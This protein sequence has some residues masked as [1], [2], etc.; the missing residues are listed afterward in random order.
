MQE[1]A[2]RRSAIKLARDT[3]LRSGR[4]ETR[5][6]PDIVAAS[7]L[8]S[9]SAGVDASTAQ[10]IYHNDLDVT[11][12]LV[13]CSEAAIARLGDEM[14][15][16]PLSIVLTDHK[17]RILWRSERDRGIGRLLD[18]VSLAPGFNYAEDSVGTNGIG[19]V[20]ESG[21]PLYIVGPEHFHEQLQPF[22]CAGSPIR[23]PLTNRVEGVLDITCL[24][25]FA[26]PLMH[27]LVRSAAHEIEQNLLVDRSQC[28]Q[29]LFEAFVRVDARTH[30]AVMAI[31]GTMVM[32]NA[33]AQGLF[34]PG[35][36]WAIHEHARYLM[37]SRGGPADRIELPS[38]R[39]VHL[40]G[41]RVVVGAD[42]AG[43]VVVVSLVEAGSAVPMS[44]AP[45]LAPALPAGAGTA[46]G[47][48]T[49][50]EMRAAAPVVAEQPTRFGDGRSLLW[51]RACAGISEALVAAEPL[52]VIGESGCGKR[53]LV[54]DLFERVV[55]GGRTREF[56]AEDLGDLHAEEAAGAA[57]TERTL[58]IVSNINR[59]DAEG[60]AVFDS[61]LAA[62]AGSGRPVSVAAT[63]SDADLD[64]D[65][66]FRAVLAHFE[67]AVTV[68]PL[69]HRTEDIA[70]LVTHLLRGSPGQRGPGVSTAAMRVLSRY[71]WPRNIRQLE[72]AL[73]F[74]RL[75]RPVG[76]IQPEDLPGYCHSGAQRQLSTLEA[77]ERD[78][79]VTALHDAEGNRA[80]TAAMLGIAR[81]SL[82][83]K[84][85][86]FGIT[87][88]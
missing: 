54:A 53:S 12:R 88:A 31:G 18:G 48:E 67:K 20:L 45:V 73:A 36:Q 66:P 1:S 52:L 30:A 40:R 42:V 24:S 81:S 85:K 82:Y 21:R 19:T 37:T 60:V 22:A 14:A 13:R 29:A 41:T 75:K 25:E 77:G 9:F 39:H 69:R 35:E 80:R 79:I 38:G 56:A 58:Y 74:A 68:A 10:A 15:E 55:A 4:T 83:R 47:P 71:D 32:G 59:L 84:L 28:Q 23:D 33:A 61:F 76:E 86:T 44:Q 87:A 70:L 63:V 65:L 51:K 50:A 7:W 11:G 62:L 26:S 5:A 46:M 2:D 72:E 27:S 3:F 43:I 8:R 6:V 64:S 78:L 34:E 49:G 17:A 16:M 57:V